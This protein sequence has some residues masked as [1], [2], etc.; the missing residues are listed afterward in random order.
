MIMSLLKLPD[1]KALRLSSKCCTNLG[2][3]FL[4]QPFVFRPDRDDFARFDQIARDPFFLKTIDSIRFEIGS[5]D[6]FNVAGNLCSWLL[7][8][9]EHEVDDDPD[10]DLSLRPI[11]GKRCRVS[12]KAGG[13][14]EY[15]HWKYKCIRS[16]QDYQDTERIEKVL[17]QLT[18]LSRIDIS[19]KSS[20][21]RSYALLTAWSQG[22]W[23]TQFKRINREFS[24][25]LEAI[26]AVSPRLRPKDLRHD[27][28]PVTFFAIKP[29]ILEIHT[30]PFA[31]LQTLHLT[32]KATDQA[33]TK[34]LWERIG[35][36]LKSAANLKDLRFGFDNEYVG[37]VG[38]TWDSVDA[39]DEWY[40]PLW[41]VW[42]SHVWPH[43][44]SIRL[45]G[46]LVCEFGLVD[47]LTRHKA[48]YNVQ[49]YSVGLSYGSYR[50]LLSQL[51][52]K[53]VL[54]EFGL[55]GRLNAF[56]SPEESWFLPPAMEMNTTPHP[57]SSFYKDWRK[58]AYS[59]GQMYHLRM[60]AA[61]ELRDFVLRGGEWPMKASD[62]TLGLED[63][64]VLK[65]DETDCEKL[66]TINKTWDDLD[67]AFSG[68]EKSLYDYETDE[69]PA[70]IEDVMQIFDD[71]GFDTNGFDRNGLDECGVH[72]SRVHQIW[73]L[74]GDEMVNFVERSTVERI[75]DNMNAFFWEEKLS[76]V[77]AEL[78]VINRG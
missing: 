10:K 43:L 70:D 3:T 9:D 71:N 72:F 5:L 69:G 30:R 29:E 52:T 2:G 8:P 47:D 62:V 19:L 48:L 54:R 24:V 51:R 38:G 55:W 35:T 27:E 50:E 37:G 32:V 7:Y 49:L 61:A 56:H 12:R 33:P 13:V 22:G 34:T 18:R 59:A 36:V 65:C 28:L 67:E 21:F 78:P 16:N 40:L 75:K 58:V 1:I 77:P 64:Q 57:G 41:R 63:D 20:S 15:S 4:F 46:L 73:E 14:S 11:D 66:D 39:P 60:K 26:Q 31:H 68:W 6:I 53:L 44:T 76:G 25:I 17:R 23:N 45:D 74:D 42:G